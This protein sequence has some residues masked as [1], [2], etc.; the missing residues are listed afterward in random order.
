LPKVYVSQIAAG[1][2]RLHWFAQSSPDDTSYLLDADSAP[3]PTY[4]AYATMTRL[5]ERCEYAGPVDFGPLTQGHLFYRD[6]QAI[7]VAWAT[8]GLREATLEA[9]LDVLGGYDY[10]DR[11]IEARGSGG[12]VTLKLTDHPIYLVMNR[13]AWNTALAKSELQRRLKDLAVE[14]PAALPA[15][16][17]AAAN[18][19]ATDPEAMNR[20][21]HLMLAGK[22]LVLTGEAPQVE[23]G[24]GDRVASARRSIE[25]REGPD[26]YLR[27]SRI[28]LDWAERWYVTATRQTGILSGGYAWLAQQCAAAAQKM[29][30]REPAAYPGV[31]INAFLEPKDIRA[32]DPKEPMDEKFEFEI[33]RQPGETFDLELTVWNYTRRRIA[34]NLEPRLPAGWTVA[35]GPQAYGVEPGK[36]Q[37]FTVTVK[38]GDKT[39]PGV[40]AVGGRT[41][42]S[43]QAIQEIHTQRV[44][45]GTPD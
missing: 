3:N 39:E 10:V 21:H 7:V 8:Q 40:Y 28:V 16:I 6:Q 31:V 12:R 23:G 43:G 24:T 30:A 33:Q 5:L 18:T 34:G 22:Q 44:R 15:Q 13:N 27:E 4:C 37:R 1:V 36:F 17:D 19:A 42:F 9:G 26:G 29:S 45:I 25:T 38:V 32:G 14:T 2:D 20:L 41:T 35:G 11:P